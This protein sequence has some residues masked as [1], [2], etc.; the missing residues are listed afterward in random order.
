MKNFGHIRAFTVTATILVLVLQA[1]WLYYA[2]SVVQQQTQ[3]QINDTFKD[4]SYKELRVREEGSKKLIQPKKPGEKR[5]EQIIGSMPINIDEDP[6]ILL[7]LVLQEHLYKNKVYVS[8]NYMDSAF[9][10]MME[11]KNIYGR[12]I[13]NR[14]NTETGEVLET[15][16]KKYKGTL[17]GAL[18][19]SVI[20]VRM[21]KSEGV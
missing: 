5:G 1:A 17:S 14:I 6:E 13:I 3:K 15:T 19:S 10:S 18:I 2:Y 11:S 4:V 21:D 7:N 12:F 9:R 8:L 20:P 16:D